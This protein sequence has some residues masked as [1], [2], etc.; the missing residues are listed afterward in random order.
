MADLKIVV[1]KIII[2]EKEEQKD[3]IEKKTDNCAK[4]EETLADNEVKKSTFLNF[5]RNN[6]TFCTLTVTFIITLV[7]YLCYQFDT[8][9]LAY[10]NIDAASLQFFN[11]FRFYELVIPAIII[12]IFV[13]YYSLQIK[14]PWYFNLIILLVFILL[15]SLNY[16]NCLQ[17]ELKH[18]IIL[19]FLTVLNLCA[20]V[21]KLIS[22]FVESNNTQEAEKKIIKKQKHFNVAL[23]A[24]L[25]V[26]AFSIVKLFTVFRFKGKNSEKNTEIF[27]FIES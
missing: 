12:L 15:F 3:S 9:Y 22:Y 26:L 19:I 2:N 11:P 14:S 27:R 17:L 4:Q 13:V 8:G 20:L 24:C 1:K 6:G 7:S 18:F 10:F 23:I 25:L 21:S 16:I 5:V